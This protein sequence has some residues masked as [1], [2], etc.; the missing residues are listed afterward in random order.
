MK[1]YFFVRI[2]K[3]VADG[4]KIYFPEVSIFFVTVLPYQQK[5]ATA[6]ICWKKANVT[7]LL[8]HAPK[9]MS[10]TSNDAVF[11][12]NKSRKVHLLPVCY[13]TRQKHRIKTQ[14]TSNDAVFSGNKWAFHALLHVCYHSRW[15]G[16]CCW[17]WCRWRWGRA[18]KR[19]FVCL[20]LPAGRARIASKIV[21]I[22]LWNRGKIW[23]CRGLAGWRTCR[24]TAE[25]FTSHKKHY[26][27]LTPGKR[28]QHKE[29]R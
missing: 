3:K 19:F 13:H 23:Q 28:S 18:K 22:F 4:C 20:R 7:S 29:R 2:Y 15:C 1:M 26:V 9:A 27:N 17:W 12:G 6:R 21:S 10:K 16:C 8:P 14:K 25:N 5:L 11:S 24:L